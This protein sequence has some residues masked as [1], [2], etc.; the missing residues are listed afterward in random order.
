MWAGFVGDGTSRRLWGLLV[1][2]AEAGTSG[3]LG[4]RWDG[5]G[6]FVYACH[7]GAN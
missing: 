2:G 5:S 7:Y 6:S 1:C 3:G 4:I